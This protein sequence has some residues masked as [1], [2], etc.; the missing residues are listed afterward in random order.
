MDLFKDKHVLITGASSGIGEAFAR[1]L[2]KRNAHVLLVA[3]R[4]DRLVKLCEEFNEAR[5]A[6]ARYLSVDLADANQVRE[7]TE[8][9]NNEHIDLLI[10]NAGFG[11][12]GRYEKLDR[13]REE[14]MMQVN[15]IAPLLLT[16]AVLPQMKERGAG[17]IINVSSIAA[18]QPLPFMATYA[19]TKSVN[20]SHSLALREELAGSEIRVLAV[21]P[22]PVQTEFGGV[23]RVPGKVT[24][25]P[26]TT[27]ETVVG[28]ALRA[29]ERGKA[30]VIPGF[31]AKLLA[32][33]CR[34]LP[35]WLTVPIAG[36]ALRSVLPW[37]ETENSDKKN[38]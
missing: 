35:A 22:G 19:A 32:L 24:A 13:E 31:R 27:V 14:S 26:R 33:P 16:H 37:A 20:L 29:F 30:V 6:S 17:G 36:R 3:R 15:A 8:R 38:T 4:E 11:S 9:L 1:A 25:G 34:V 28:D 5:H 18:F 7:L 10:N 23:A 21:C 12:F 2:H